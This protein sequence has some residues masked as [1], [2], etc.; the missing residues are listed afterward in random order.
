MKKRNERRREP[1]SLPGNGSSVPP[2]STQT[3][4]RIFTPAQVRAG[5]RGAAL[6]RHEEVKDNGSCQELWQK[7]KCVVL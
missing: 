5:V 3:L 1:S 2:V 4:P 6:L 7:L